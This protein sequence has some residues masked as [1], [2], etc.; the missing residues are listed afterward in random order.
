MFFTVSDICDRKGRLYLVFE[1]M[2][3]NLLEVLEEAGGSGGLPVS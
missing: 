1:Y 3:K 2:D